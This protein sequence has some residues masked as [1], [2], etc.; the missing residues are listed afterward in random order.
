M[1]IAGPLTYLPPPPL[2]VPV[3]VLVP[4]PAASRSTA[5]HPTNMAST[6]KT[7]KGMHVLDAFRRFPTGNWIKGGSQMLIAWPTGKLL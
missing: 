7:G 3:P 5:L 4:L 6:D 2:R 1:P